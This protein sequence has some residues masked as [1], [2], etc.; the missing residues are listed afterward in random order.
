MPI[1][2][3]FVLIRDGPVVTKGRRFFVSRMPVKQPRYRKEFYPSGVYEFFGWKQVVRPPIRAFGR[4]YETELQ[5]SFHIPPYDFRIFDSD[6]LS[7]IALADGP[8]S[9]F[10]DQNLH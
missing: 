9:Q 1:R 3:I 4:I 7:S 5:C 6:M 2:A 8:F 10:A